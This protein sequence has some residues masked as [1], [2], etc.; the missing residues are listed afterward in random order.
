MDTHEFA[1]VGFGF[2]LPSNVPKRNSKFP[3]DKYKHQCRVEEYIM[4]GIEEDMSVANQ[5]E[6]FVETEN[7]TNKNMYDGGNDEFMIKSEPPFSP[8]PLIALDGN[9]QSEQP[10]VITTGTIVASLPK[11]D[12]LWV[13]YA[14]ICSKFTDPLPMKNSL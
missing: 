3:N 11:V 1:G 9:T 10:M 5:N 7:V 12:Q 4:Q 2:A 6:D 8:L 13:I 14:P